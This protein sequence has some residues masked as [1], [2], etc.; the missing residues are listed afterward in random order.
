MRRAA[1]RR[2][3][4]FTTLAGEVFAAR[5]QETNCVENRIGW[6]RPRERLGHP[7]KAKARCKLMASVN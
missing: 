2:M 5:W 7:A 6:N 1:C 3:E 4:T